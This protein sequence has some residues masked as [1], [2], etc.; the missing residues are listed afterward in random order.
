MGKRIFF[1]IIVCMCLI[2]GMAAISC[3]LTSSEQAAM[4]EHIQEMRS[5]KPAEFAAMSQRAG[6][7]TDCKSCH[8]PKWFEEQNRKKHRGP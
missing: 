1:L 5:K 8:T 7:I 4:Q 3:A 6:N 2:P